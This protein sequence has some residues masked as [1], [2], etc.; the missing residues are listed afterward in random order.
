MNHTVI[1]KPVDNFS[2]SFSA[3]RRGHSSFM[4][5]TS[6]GFGFTSFSSSPFHS[7]FF[8]EPDDHFMFMEDSPFELRPRFDH[9]FHFHHHG[10][11]SRHRSGPRQPTRHRPR[12]DRVIDERPQQTTGTETYG[13]N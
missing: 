8:S 5:S 1:I 11:G 4:F 6:P 9:L 13:L 2:I 12:T 3:D 7:S 10:V